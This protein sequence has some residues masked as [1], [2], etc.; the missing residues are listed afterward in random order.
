MHATSETT[1][2]T[3]IDQRHQMAMAEIPW[4]IPAFTG[5][6]A[7]AI[8]TLSG[9]HAYRLLMRPI[10]KLVLSDVPGCVVPASGWFIDT[11]TGHPIRDASGNPLRGATQYLRIKIENQ[12]RTFAQNVSISVT[13]ITSAVAGSGTT[14]F[15]EE[16]FDL[17]L[18]NSSQQRSVFNLPAGAHRF[19][20]LVHA[21]NEDK[22]SA[23]TELAFD[24]GNAAHRLE[25]LKPKTGQRANYKAKVFASADNAT[26]ITEEFG[27]EFAGTLDS[28][29][30]VGPD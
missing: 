18:A 24:F 25:A 21:T 13:E 9:Q 28:L 27:W 16:V 30:I 3:T 6:L 17:Y 23:P 7:G 2:E 29:K 11:R 20:D 12:G 22:V 26:S 4:I 19:V 8:L 5:G 10:L 1:S 14:K 15:E